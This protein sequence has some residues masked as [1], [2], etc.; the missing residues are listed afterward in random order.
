MLIIIFTFQDLSKKMRQLFESVLELRGVQERFHSQTEFELKR[1]KDLDKYIEV[2]GT[3]NDIED[4]DAEIK[5]MFML[6]VNKYENIIKEI[7]SSYKVNIIVYYL[8]ITFLPRQHFQA[9][10][11]KHDFD[12]YRFFYRSIWENY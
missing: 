11:L 4:N 6:E 5:E 9:I 3:C 7:D 1:R 2:H 10:F 12:F 8:L